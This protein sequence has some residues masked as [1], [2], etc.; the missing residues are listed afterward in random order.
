MNLEQ[1]IFLAT[2]AGFNNQV[3]SAI[4]EWPKL[5]LSFDRFADLVSHRATKEFFEHNDQHTKTLLRS[6]REWCAKIAE[7]EVRLVGV[8]DNVVAFSDLVAFRIRERNKE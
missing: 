4:A 3:I 7:D 5:A 2:E 6:E 8:T 1:I